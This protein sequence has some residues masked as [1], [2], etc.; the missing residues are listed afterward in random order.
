MA[1]VIGSSFS[2]YTIKPLLLCCQSQ[3]S[4]F[5][6]L[7]GLQSKNAKPAVNLRLEQWI[8]GRPGSNCFC[9][10][11]KTLCFFHVT[12]D[13]GDIGKTQENGDEVLVLRTKRSQRFDLLVGIKLRL[14][15]SHVQ[16]VYVR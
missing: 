7:S 9:L 15:Q 11:G 1:H 14:I 8:E 3:G 4:A 2:L 10:F 16:K 13:N 6:L 12:L 5:F